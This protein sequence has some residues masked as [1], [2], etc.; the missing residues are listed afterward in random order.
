MK[1]LKSSIWLAGLGIQALC[2]VYFI[3]RTWR[4]YPTNHWGGD[5]RWCYVLAISQMF[6]AVL[7]LMTK[8]KV[9]LLWTGAIFTIVFCVLIFFF[10][11][12]NVL[13]EY[14][15]WIRRGMPASFLDRGN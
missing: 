5:V 3:W 13:V 7:F 6:W 11:Q 8:R 4:Y 15:N 10:D 2:L 1:F 14:E 9:V 12:F